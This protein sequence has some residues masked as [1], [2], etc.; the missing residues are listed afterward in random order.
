MMRTKIISD[1]F[2][3]SVCV[4]DAA[5][6]A[7]R[8]VDTDQRLRRAAVSASRPDRLTF[9]PGDFCYFWRDAAGWSPGMAT[10]VSQ[11][12]QGHHSVD[13]VGRI[14][15]QSAGQLSHLTER[16]RMAQE[17]VRESQDPGQDTSHVIGEP[18]LPQQPSRSSE[19]GPNVG[20][21]VP[22]QP[23]VSMPAPDFFGTPG[24]PV[25]DDDH[26]EQPP[27]E[28]VPHSSSWE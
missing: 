22:E 24:D 17:D 26:D 28:P 21:V 27:A 5:R 25:D 10:V 18:V 23:D 16:E 15:K 11:V 1:E 12:G 14:F 13:Y 2:A 4:R 9:E 19:H 3:R 8:A 6:R 7:F 20:A